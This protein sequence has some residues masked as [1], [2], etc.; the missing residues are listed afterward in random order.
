MLSGRI[1]L[2]ESERGCVERGRHPSTEGRNVHFQKWL[3]G[4]Y[5]AQWKG[6][7]SVMLYSSL[8][9]FKL[10]KASNNY[11]DWKDGGWV[12]TLWANTLMNNAAISLSLS[13]SL[14]QFHPSFY[15]FLCSDLCISLWKAEKRYLQSLS[16]P[17]NVFYT[18]L[19]SKSIMQWFLSLLLG[20]RHSGI[21]NGLH[22]HFH[23]IVNSSIS[24][25]GMKQSWLISSKD[26]IVLSFHVELKHYSHPKEAKSI[27]DTK[28]GVSLM[29]RDLEML[30]LKAYM[31]INNNNN[32][33]REV[34]FCSVWRQKWRRTCPLSVNLYTVCSDDQ[35]QDI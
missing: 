21:T 9:H 17:I 13:R 25:I 15:Q 12:D 20:W 32:N 19:K 33:L 34:V 22:F 35:T 29:W 14:F 3:V 23:F 26:K 4:F 8:W 1:D 11:A 24:F 31:L 7:I 30:S 5:H 2:W 28:L 10:I 16:V 18:K 27:K 6:D